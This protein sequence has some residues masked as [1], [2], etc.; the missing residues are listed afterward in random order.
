M[1][2]HSHNVVIDHLRMLGV[3]GGIGITVFIA[4]TLTMLLIA[5]REAFMFG[6]AQTVDRG[7]MIGFAL[8]SV[9]YIA[10]NMLSDSF[11]PST[12]PIFWIVLS[13]TLFSRRLML[14]GISVDSAPQYLGRLKN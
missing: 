7:L 5:V 3:P 13:S 8:G 12:S 9:A 14:H 11:G 10:A 4:A 2:T 1:P 6:R